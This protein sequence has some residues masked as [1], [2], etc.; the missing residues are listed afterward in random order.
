MFD[1]PDPI[2]RCQS[3]VAKGDA[4]VAVGLVIGIDGNEAVAF[5]RP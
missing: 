4:K 1:D 5:A 2:G 3:A